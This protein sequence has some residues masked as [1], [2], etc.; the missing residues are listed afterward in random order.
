[1]SLHAL[2]RYQVPMRFPVG[3]AIS[4]SEL[5]HRCNADEEALT[6]LVQHAVT[7]RFLAQPEAGVVAHTA[8]SAMMA[9]QPAVT[10]FVGYVCEDLRPAAASIP[11][12]LAKWP[13]PPW[14]PNQTGHKLGAG[15]TSTFWDSMAGDPARSRRFA[16]SMSLMQRMPGC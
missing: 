3:E 5:A 4:T 15:T 12:A 2:Y 6:R 7:R 14:L 16:S 11:D 10:D 1:M 8:F 9:A 13:R